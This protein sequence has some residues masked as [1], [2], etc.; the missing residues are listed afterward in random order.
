MV[1]WTRAQSQRHPWRGGSAFGRFSARPHEK[2]GPKPSSAVIRE[3]SDRVRPKSR[4]SQPKAPGSMVSRRAWHES[5]RR[6]GT[7]SA[8]DDLWGEDDDQNPEHPQMQLLDLHEDTELEC[9]RQA[10]RLPIAR[11]RA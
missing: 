4:P 8:A 6:S 3:V 2:T 11:G 10:G 9:D 5:H 1:R 7:L